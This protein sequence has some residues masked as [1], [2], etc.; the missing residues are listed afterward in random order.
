MVNGTAVATRV[1]WTVTLLLA[2]AAF[3]LGYVGFEDYLHGQDAFRAATPFDKIYYTVQ[4]FV[5]D[6]APFTTIGPYP[7]TLEF[8]R[9]L[10]PVTT[11]L[12]V[13]QALAFL[14]GDWLRGVIFRRS[15][16]H[17]VVVGDG[18]AAGVLAQRLVREKQVVVL[19][20]SALP[21]EHA[22]RHGLLIV[23]GDP[24]DAVT[25]RAAGIRRASMVYALGRTGA[26]NAGVAL[27]VRAARK[28]PVS[29][30]AQVKDAVLVTALRARQ[31]SASDDS[32]FH[33]DFFSLEDAAARVLLDVHP[34]GDVGGSTRPVVIAGSGAFPRAVLRELAQRQVPTAA[35]RTVTVVT[36]QP[37]VVTAFSDEHGLAERG[38]DVTPVPAMPEHAGSAA[39][40]VCFVEADDVLR[41][42]LGQLRAGVGRV[43]LCLNRLAEL[44]NALDG[45]S[46]FDDA[47]G[48]L[49]V[50]GILDAGCDPA[51]LRRDL[52]DQLARALHAHYLATIANGG[53]SAVPWEQ[54]ARRFQEDNRRQAEHIG[55]KLRRIEAV[56]M[57][58]GPGFTP[59]RY[60]RDDD[61]DEVLMLA[62]LEHERWM[63]A[64]QADKVVWGPERTETTHPDIKPWSELTDRTRKKDVEFVEALPDILAGA[65]FQIV[66]MAPH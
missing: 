40:Y 62:E 58:A 10:A 3:T 26:L 53:D 16:G 41:T 33:L 44:G 6:P 66:R 21:V 30:Y 22:R 5:I 59:F 15:P 61:G 4:L 45:E 20:G 28:R 2:A 18:P 38:L 50:F 54:L 8:A 29:V 32:G 35:R 7:F 14:V 56:L 24:T 25:L 12:A 17:T 48:R 46:I 55:T 31:L 63:A 60:R 37:D 64:K 13:V 1:L 47:A 52:V 42:G 11:I 51:L 65:G 9:F 36:A 27:S 19:I 23:P 43:V 49:A 57:P 39:V 34:P